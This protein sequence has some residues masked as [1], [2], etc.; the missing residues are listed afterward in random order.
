MWNE[1]I[2][3]EKRRQKDENTLGHRKGE[4]DKERKKE[5]K[6][7]EESHNKRV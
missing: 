3:L 2:Y 5:R 7:R 1:K 4:E 6:E